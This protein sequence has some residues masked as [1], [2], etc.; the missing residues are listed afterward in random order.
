MN[1]VNI[2]DLDK[3]KITKVKTW[4]VYFTYDEQRYF[5]HDDSDEDRCIGLYKKND[6]NIEEI[7]GAI[8]LS[9]P[10]DFIR[11]KKNIKP[12]K[13]WNS[14][15]CNIVYN[16]IDKEYFVKKLTRQG[17]IDSLFQKDIDELNEKIAFNK[18]IITG[19]Q[20]KID[21]REREIREMENEF[22]GNSTD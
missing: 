18:S 22:Y 1:K 2:T 19:L 14:T 11:V 21:E 17:I 9:Y 13:K 4:V 15:A 8:T 16:Q 10:C 6:K 3:L 20:R 5:L 12:P 7:G